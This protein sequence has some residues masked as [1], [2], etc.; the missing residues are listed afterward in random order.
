MK[1][2]KKNVSVIGLALVHTLDSYAETGEE[3]TKI[4]EQIVLQNSL[5]DFE[6]VKLANSG[7]YN[8]ALNL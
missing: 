8:K 2:R 4:L 1:L 6:G 3:Y 7:Q 5:E